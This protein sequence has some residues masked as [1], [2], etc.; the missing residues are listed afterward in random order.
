L[1]SVLESP[2]WL[3]LTIFWR[4]YR[5]KKEEANNQYETKKYIIRSI[6][7]HWQEQRK[8]TE[9]TSTYEDHQRNISGGRHVCFSIIDL[10]LLL[11][12]SCLDSYFSYKVIAKADEKKK[13]KNS[14]W[15]KEVW[16]KLN[17]FIK[18]FSYKVN[19]SFNISSLFFSKS[20]RQIY[21]N[22]K[23]FLLLIFFFTWLYVLMKGNIKSWRRDTSTYLLVYHIRRL[24]SYSTHTHNKQ[25]EFWWPYT[26]VTTAS[27]QSIIEF[28]YVSEKKKERQRNSLSVSNLGCFF[29]FYSLS[30][31][32]VDPYLYSLRN[33][34]NTDVCSSIW[35]T[36]KLLDIYSIYIYIFVMSPYVIP[37]ALRLIR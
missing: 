9:S 15:K 22:N 33:Q 34:T 5:K 27:I 37:S 36:Q 31:T 10:F 21:K 18:I 28:I 14:L 11:H 29:L 13:R 24:S 26:Y 2:W 6:D 12:I 25:L 4:T 16:L 17:T 20:N 19:L 7:R 23:L 3:F 35:R 8:R 30:N 1:P 32:I